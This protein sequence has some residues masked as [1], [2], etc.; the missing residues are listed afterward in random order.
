MFVSLRLNSATHSAHHKV[1]EV[2]CTIR[3]CTSVCVCV[4]VGKYIETI[5]QTKSLTDSVV[6]IVSQRGGRRQM[7]TP[8]HPKRDTV[9]GGQV[10]VSTTGFKAKAS[11]TKTQLNHNARTSRQRQATQTNI[12]THP[13]VLESKHMFSACGCQR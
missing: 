7:L 5:T 6:S 10:H 9:V 4:C 1:V 11:N 2:C 3:V 12:Y 8:T 13:N